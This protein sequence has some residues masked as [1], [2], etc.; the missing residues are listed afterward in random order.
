MISLIIASKE[1]TNIKENNN[2]NYELIEIDNELKKLES[3]FIK[4]YY[5]N[6]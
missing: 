2:I 3:F 6:K 1:N 4:N 5:G